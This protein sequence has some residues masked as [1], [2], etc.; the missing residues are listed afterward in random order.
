M[1]KTSK[2][3]NATRRPPTGT[4]KL[5]NREQTAQKRLENF[6]TRSKPLERDYRI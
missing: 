2:L 4:R 1:K 3:D 6:R 5:E